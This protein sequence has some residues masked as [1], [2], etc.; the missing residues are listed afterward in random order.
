VLLASAE[1]WARR[2]GDLDSRFEMLLSLV[3][4]VA[5]AQ[6]GG[7]DTLLMHEDLRRALSPLA[8]AVPSTVLWEVFD[9]VHSTQDAIAH[10]ANPLL[11]F[12][13]M[14]FKIGDVY[15]RAR[16]RDRR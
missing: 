11:A 8:A 12:E 14:L 16:Q 1:Q 7:E 6:A 10:N 3:R 5:V 2:K 9:I 15:E 13:V 4:D